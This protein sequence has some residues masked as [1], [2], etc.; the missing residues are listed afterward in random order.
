[1]RNTINK[2]AVTRA[3]LIRTNDEWQEWDFPRF[4]EALCK[5][6]ERN[7]I[8]LS[9]KALATLLKREK[10]LQTIQNKK[11]SQVCVYCANKGHRS[12]DCKKVTAVD[13]RRKILS[14][15]RLCFNCT[16]LKHRESECKSQRSF[17]I[18]KSKHHTSICD[19]T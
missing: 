17:I 1:M 6:T 14:E 15:K 18:C 12:S 8:D 5:W 10:L 11:L 4:V 19:Q 9:K 2:L 3:D 16:G 7:P 13:Q